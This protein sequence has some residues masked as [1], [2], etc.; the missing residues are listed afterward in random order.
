MAYVDGV[1][2]GDGRIL[3]IEGEAGIGKSR[4]A[5]ELLPLAADRGLVGLSGAA[6]SIEQQ[7]TYRAWRDVFSSYFGLEDGETTAQRRQ[8]VQD[9]VLE[10]VPELAERLP[11][12][13]DVLNLDLPNTPLVRALTG[14]ARHNSLVLFLI[15]LL[16]KWLAERPL[17]LLL[18]DVHWFDS[19]SWDLALQVAR[20]FMLEDRAFF[21]VL[22]MRPLAAQSSE[23]L[24]ALQ[25]I[26]V[27]TATRT[28]LLEPLPAADTVALAAARL[29]LTAVQL[30]TTITELIQTRAGGNPFFAEEIV[31]A[32]RDNGLLRLNGQDPEL[33]GD[34]EEISQTLPGTLQGIVLSR[35]DRLTPAQQLTLKVASV[36]GRSFGFA[37]L[38]GLLNEHTQISEPVLHE[39]LA[40]FVDRDLTALELPEPDLTFVFKH[41]ITREVAYETLLHTQRRQLHRSV[42]LWYER[43]LGE[44][45]LYPY[46]AVMVYHWHQAGDKEREGVYARLAGLK[47]AA[48]YANQEALAYFDRAL[49]LT[50][51]SQLRERFDLLLAREQVNFYYA[52]REAQARDLAALGQLAEQLDDN[53]DRATVAWRQARYGEQTGNYMAAAQ[54][55]QQAV[56]WA[57]LAGDS[58]S[59]AEALNQWAHALVRQGYYEEA[60]A[61]YEQALGLNR[62]AKDERREGQTLT[63]V[64]TLHFYW[65]KFEELNTFAEE[66]IALNDKYVDRLG[67]AR[68]LNLLGLACY[69]TEQFT[70]AIRHYEQAL[71]TYTD[72]GDRRGQAAVYSNLGNVYADYGDYEWAEAYYERAIGIDRQTGDRGGE[73]VNL[74]TLGMLRNELGEYEA[75]RASC[76]AAL[77]I[78]VEIGD[79]ANEIYA[80]MTLANILCNG[81]DYVP[82]VAYA[83][84]AWGINQDLEQ[85]DFDLTILIEWSRALL[86][87]EQWPEAREVC[88]RLLVVCEQH[89]EQAYRIYGLAGL[90][91]IAWRNGRSDEAAALAKE[92][93]AG[94]VEHIP[95]FF[96]ELFRVYLLCYRILADVDEG[97]AR[98]VLAEGYG[99]LM[100][101]ANKIGDEFLRDQ[102]L[103]NVGVYRD[104]VQ[105]HK[106]IGDIDAKTRRGK[107]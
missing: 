12:L 55:A 90:G 47:A 88:Q 103:E 106:R 97:E 84:Q 107:E 81:E 50:A 96:Q 37:A 73:A 75:A 94:I 32:L 6:Q 54:S 53:R 28:M 3:I 56:D 8:K 19:L 42:A 98:R 27:L 21:L 61:L 83:A 40:H 13:N 25:A 93:V 14:Q 22:V 34:P 65:G 4:L 31:Y 46:Y 41:I 17:I 59:E 58:V 24:A 68:C 1:R 26:R 78:L 18:E 38:R 2:R 23:R 35:I 70:Q 51:E 74:I 29:G 99:R 105:L 80:L 9:R 62:T 64:A 77:D 71:V 57:Q 10:L 5:A 36:I 79:R 101:R 95:E 48:Q 7:T 15:E 52:A 60:M 100:E 11:L 89:D 33:I 39:H 16:E 66:A 91:E 30:P 86:G 76:E 104:I 85:K 102:F 63:N 87:L 43:Q 44:E 45:A 49:A 67:K 69:E 20:T 82:A 92:I 72:I